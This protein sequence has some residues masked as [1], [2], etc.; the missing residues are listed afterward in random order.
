MLIQAYYYTIIINIRQRTVTQ[1]SDLVQ[2]ENLFKKQTVKYHTNN[3]FNN[4]TSCSL[5][6]MGRGNSQGKCFQR[7]SK[8][9]SLL[10][11]Y[12]YI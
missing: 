3:Y 12:I 6:N 7:N 1:N 5:P 2:S 11:I 10:K 9:L 4:I 8:I